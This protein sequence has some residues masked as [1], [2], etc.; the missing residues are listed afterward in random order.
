[1]K[2][3][4]DRMLKPEEVGVK[5]GV[6]VKTLTNWRYMQKGPKYVRMGKYIRY[7]LSEILRW[8]KEHEVDPAA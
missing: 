2:A 8:S 4:E 1:M 3:A 7:W 5:L 6:D